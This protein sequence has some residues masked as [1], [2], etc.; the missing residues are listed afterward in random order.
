MLRKQS[1]NI[2][3]IDFGL[4]SSQPDDEDKAVDI[5]VMERAFISTHPHSEPLV[6]E[7]LRAYLAAS[8][9][10]LSARVMSKLEEVPSA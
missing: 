2:A 1:G 3:F 10:H 4:A 9:P 5:Y 7:V 8:K 6:N